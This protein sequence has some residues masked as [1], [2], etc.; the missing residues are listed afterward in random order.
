MSAAE[1]IFSYENINK[2]ALGGG[3]WV[4]KIN[5]IAKIKEGLIENAS[6]CQL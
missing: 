6:F 3:G 1:A 5:E 2:F 4:G